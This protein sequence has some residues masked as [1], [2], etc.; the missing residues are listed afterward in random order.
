MVRKQLQAAMAEQQDKLDKQLVRSVLLNYLTAAADKK[1]DVELLLIRILDLDLGQAQQP[2]QQQP[3]PAADSLASQFVR[4]LESE[5]AVP[6]AA[7]PLA[8]RPVRQLAHSL[9]ASSS[10]RSDAA[11][12]RPSDQR[13]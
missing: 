2:R 9:M 7:P 6:A 8:S 3:T 1:R 13:Q 10:V 4:F 12:G 5:S 11:D